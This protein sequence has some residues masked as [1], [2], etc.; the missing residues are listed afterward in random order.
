MLAKIGDRV[1]ADSRG[2]FAAHDERV[3]IVEA[4]RLSDSHVEFCERTANLWNRQCFVGLENLLTDRAGVFGIATYLSAA[5]RFP[6]NNS[7]AHSLSVFRRDTRVLERAFRNFS[8]N[9]RL[10]EFFRTDDNG[11]G[12]DLGC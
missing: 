8:E 1:D 5:Q 10:G 12:K 3:S 4:D 6:K 9:I 2:H 11:V 7:A